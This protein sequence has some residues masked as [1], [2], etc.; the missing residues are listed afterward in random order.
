MLLVR[1]KEG[2]AFA[3]LASQSREQS[4]PVLLRLSHS[5]VVQGTYLA[6]QGPEVQ[7]SDNYPCE[8]EGMFRS[9]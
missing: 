5:F 3:L 4:P 6:L 8:L 1:K 7:R 2:K 9:V